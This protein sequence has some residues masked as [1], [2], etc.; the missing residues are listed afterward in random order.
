MFLELLYFNVTCIYFNNYNLY[1]LYY[2][3]FSDINMYFLRR[4]YKKHIF[5]QSDALCCWWILIMCV[6]VCVRGRRALLGGVC[7]GGGR[8]VPS[9]SVSS[10][11]ALSLMCESPLR[12]L[13]TA[14]D[15]W[16]LGD[17]SSQ[18][19]DT[20]APPSV[21]PRDREKSDR[22]DFTHSSAE[23][24]ECIERTPTLWKFAFFSWKSKLQTINRNAVTLHI[25]LLLRCSRGWHLHHTW[26]LWI[27]GQSFCESD[28]LPLILHSDHSP[29]RSGPWL[30]SAAAESVHVLRSYSLCLHLCTV[31][32][33]GRN[34]QAGIS[35]PDCA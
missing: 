21:R 29:A 24:M 16:S 10:L 11:A 18:C 19:A 22:G 15:V 12:G 13:A 25:R 27:V 4:Y 33:C 26:H 28:F 9:R 30:F 8:C 23:K 3:L 31:A 34:A 32:D 5:K 1:D 35:Y 2:S 6:C 7:V 17:W 14:T 20:P